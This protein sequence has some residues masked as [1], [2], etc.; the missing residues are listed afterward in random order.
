MKSRVWKRTRKQAIKRKPHWAKDCQNTPE[1]EWL[2]KQECFKCGFKGHLAAQCRNSSK[3]RY[4]H[5]KDK[6]KTKWLNLPALV[7]LLQSK[8]LQN[9]PK[10]QSLKSDLPSGIAD[11]R[12]YSKQR[13]EAWKE[14]RNN[15]LNASKARVITSKVFQIFNLSKFTKLQP[16]L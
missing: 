11:M 14:A 8:D 10:Y 13:W 12:P 7:G 3:S 6:V 1:P 4:R 5:A 15:I 16:N 2:A 9:N